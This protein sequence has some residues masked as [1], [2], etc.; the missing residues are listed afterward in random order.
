VLG[1]SFGGGVAIRAAVE[2]PDRVALLT[3]VNSIG[4]AVWRAEPEGAPAIGQLADR[5]LWD[6]GIHFPREVSRRTVG[7]VLRVIADDVARNVVRNPSAFW[8]VAGLARRADLRVEL[9]ELR[10]KGV[11]IVVLWGTEDRILPQASC[12]AISAVAGTDPE[13][14]AGN[15]SWLITDPDRFAEVMTNVLAIASSLGEEEPDDATA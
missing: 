14:I 7:P 8:R 6:W 5:P 3:L 4:G 9:E 1:H 2:A 10:A 13:F 11:P 15:H 12:D